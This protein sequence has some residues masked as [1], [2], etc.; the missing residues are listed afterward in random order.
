MKEFGWDTAEKALGRKA[1]GPGEP[2][3][4]IGVIEDFH[5]H[6]LQS[7]IEPLIMRVQ[8]NRFRHLTLN[9]NTDNLQE[10]I[11]FARAKC[12]EILP[13]YPFEFSFLD[14]DFNRQYRYEEQF[15]EIFG[16]FTFLGIFIAC[17]GLL[18]LSSFMISRKTKEIGIRKILGASVS[19]ITYKL[20][21]E[22]SKWVLAANII[23]WPL[24][25]LAMDSWLQGFAYKAEMSWWVFI[26]AGLSVLIIAAGTVVIQAVKAATANPIKALRYE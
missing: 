11:S 18:G 8:P 20:S 21:L 26:F 7:E 13:D 14:D 3:E 22:F 5:Y 17:L 4:I 23:A 15:G 10:T 16:I 9:L 19:N 1:E 24:A 6:G 2:G 25:W 12:A